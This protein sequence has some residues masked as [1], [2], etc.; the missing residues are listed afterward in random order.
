MP[1]TVTFVETMAGYVNRCP[2]VRPPDWLDD[3]D[4]H[5][6]TIV[7]A[8]TARPADSAATPVALCDLALAVNPAPAGDDGLAGIARAGTVR[9]GDQEYRV[10]AGRFV[11]L[12]ASPVR[13]RRLRYRITAET[14]TGDRL[15]LAG[16]KIVTGRPWRWWTDTSRMYVML[17]IG[18]EPA[19]VA[20][21][22]RLA[23]P[24]FARQLTT[25]RGRPLDI[26]LFLVRFAT[27]LVLPSRAPARAAAHGTGTG[28]GE[29][30]AQHRRP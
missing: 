8:A 17:S 23:I 30:T 6:T 14:D 2:P 10:T 27:R 26:V 12:A 22:V 1:H 5:D 28:T 16:V 11:A 9:L 24:A 21:T 29:G 3:P 7:R 18:H 13:G 15:D 20:G 4:G 19:T 25:L